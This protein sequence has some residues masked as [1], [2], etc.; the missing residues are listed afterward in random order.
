MAKALGWHVEKI[1]IGTGKLITTRCIWG[2]PTEFRTI[3]LSGFAVPRPTDLIQ[4]QMKSFL[5]YAAGPGVGL[6]LVGLIYAAVGNDMLL[7][8]QPTLWII[9]LQ[10]FC[11]AAIFGAFI[12]LVPLPYQDGD[13]KAWS[14]GLG[15]ILSWFVPDE[16]YA[17][18][19]R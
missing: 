18:M 10:A 12:S 3:P 1:S 15:M 8:H 7:S 2:M 16:E 14:D 6:L 9:F 4:P 19:I 5:I 17:K 11:A 13:K